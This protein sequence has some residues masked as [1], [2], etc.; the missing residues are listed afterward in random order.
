MVQCFANN[1]KVQLS[2]ISL[3]VFCN[4]FNI[5]LLEKKLTEAGVLFYQMLQKCIKGLVN[6]YGKGEGRGYVCGLEQKQ[7]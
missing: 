1:I 7:K 3:T 5:K 4:S 2:Y 6:K